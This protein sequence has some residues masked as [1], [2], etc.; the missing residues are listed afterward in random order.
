MP[1][2]ALIAE[3]E[4]LLAQTLKSELGRVWPDLEV[5]AV[6][7]D[8][9]SAVQQTL[10]LQPD[11]V[12][13]DIRM[14]GMTGLEAAADIADQWPTGAGAPHY[15]QIVFV[16]AYDEYALAA[17]EV[18]AIDYLLKPVQADR[19][20]RCKEK[21]S[22]SLA[23]KQKSAIESVASGV[24]N[25]TNRL[26]ALEQHVNQLRK[27]LDQLPMAGAAPHPAPSA[28]QQ[29]AP[30]QTLQ[31]G[32]GQQIRLVP[33]AEVLYFEA[34]DKYV[35]VVTAEHEHLIRLP[36]KDLLPQL[37]ADEFWQVHRSSVVRVSAIG[38][39]SRDESGR[40]V[41]HLR[42]RP[43]QLVVSRLYADRFK[44]M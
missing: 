6:V 34:A 16:T 24:S 44:A 40:Q 2:R 11:V 13:L 39:V 22:H 42:A 28:G 14:P 7:G 5:V 33:L 20:L 1:I 18:N 31:V 32:V 35:R 3:D 29:A 17:F 38:H 21:L 36:L 41:I 19:L 25:D 30:L 12:F 23:D 10:A 27:L 15:P 4:P 26:D 9:L 8:G 37:N 43:D